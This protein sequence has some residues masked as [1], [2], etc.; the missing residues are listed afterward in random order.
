MVRGVGLRT[1]AVGGQLPVR[2]VFWL[3]ALVH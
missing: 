3:L 2:M 1:D